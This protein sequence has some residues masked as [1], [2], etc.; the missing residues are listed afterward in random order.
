MRQVVPR[1]L[2]RLITRTELW[3][4]NREPWS[5]AWSVDP[6]RSILAWSWTQHGHYRRRYTA[7]MNDPAA[8]HLDFR[9][10]RSRR[11]IDAFASALGQSTTA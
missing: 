11:E 10:L 4:G 7:A 2:R 8:A 1:T 6:Q 9:V 3:N 5:N